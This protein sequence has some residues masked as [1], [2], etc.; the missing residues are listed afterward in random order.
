MAGSIFEITDV[1][2]SAEKTAW[3]VE[4]LLCN[5][6]VYELHD[7]YQIDREIVAN[8]KSPYS[9]SA[10]LLRMNLFEKAVQ[11]YQH[12]LDQCNETDPASEETIV[13]CYWGLSGVFSKQGD[14]D[15]A[16]AY[17]A[18]AVEKSQDR[19]VLLLRSYKYLSLA[20]LEIHSHQDALNY[21]MKALE[22]QRKIDDSQDQIAD[23]LFNI[24]LIYFDQ[25]I[26]DTKHALEYLNQALSIYE[27]L[28]MHSD[29]IRCYNAIAQVYL[30]KKKKEVAL[31]YHFKALKI[32]DEF[33]PSYLPYYIDAY[34]SLGRAYAALHDYEQAMNYYQKALDA[35]LKYEP[36]NDPHIAQSYENIGSIYHAQGDYMK[37]I[38]M[39]DK[40]IE[41]RRHV[42]PESHPGLVGM[43]S[44]RDALQEFA[45]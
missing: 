7:I 18:L 41:I 1:T 22:M 21:Q 34:E 8:A 44:T 26:R 14:F 43:I 30:T 45:T 19:P 16:L 17:A 6:N 39:Y 32:V 29:L 28:K 11:Y 10:V 13:N 4:L 31:D 33:Y 37:A 5:E 9:L 36:L 27:E 35:E 42:Q 40:A 23:T 38:E 25:L 15:I 20:H 2:F 12:I 24:G 3:T